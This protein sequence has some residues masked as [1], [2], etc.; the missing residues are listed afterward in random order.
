MLHKEA[1]SLLCSA[2]KS[3]LPGEIAHYKLAPAT[4]SLNYSKE[5]IENSKESAVAIIIFPI[6]EISHV[7]YIKRSDYNGVHSAQI[8]FPGGKK[9]NKDATLLETSLRELHE[10]VGVESTAIK[11]I[12]KLTP[13][14]IPIS[15][16]MVHPHVFFSE[17]E[18]HFIPNTRE[19]QQII[20]FPL[21]ELISEKI[22]GKTVIKLGNGLQLPTPFLNINGHVLWGASAMISSELREM[23]L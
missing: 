13:L 7:L 18:L 4:R 22:L 8:A 11:F 5:Q 3:P 16:F 9:D 21:K 12:G 10:E 20:P 23:I 1:I 15:K 2:F 6:K 14:Y 19:V 17:T